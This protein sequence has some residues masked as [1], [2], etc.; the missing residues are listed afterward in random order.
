MSEGMD[1]GDIL[2]QAKIKVDKDD[3][4]PDIFKKFESF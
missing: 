1:E 2:S 3:K 4:T